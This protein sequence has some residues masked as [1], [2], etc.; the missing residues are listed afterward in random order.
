M[1]VS[2]TTERYDIENLQDQVA[3]DPGAPEFPALAEALRRIGRAGDAR[4]VS[5]VG[6]EHS[7]G[8]MAGR[9]SLGLALLELGEIG[10]AERALSQILDALLEPYRLAAD[11]VEAGPVPG[12]DREP[13]FGEGLAQLEIEQAF[14]QAEA[15][16][17]QMFS[18]DRMAEQALLDHAPLDERDSEAV[19]VGE[20]GPFDTLTM[21]ELLEQQ[22][23]R[24]GAEVIRESLGE[25]SALRAAAPEPG[26]AGRPSWD[27]LE[28]RR[29]ESEATQR[30]RVLATLESWLHNL[31]RG[32]A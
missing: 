1:A 4:R 6:L 31:Q 13:A 17:D 19:V 12:D 22:G 25:S 23:D 7:P 28:Q 8:R 5:E 27:S 32:A 2:E 9:V 18:T 10:E 24:A 29:R 26:F 21:A 11:E 15:E 20:G 16:S 14:E 3:G 30:T